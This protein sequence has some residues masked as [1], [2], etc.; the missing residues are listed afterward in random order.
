M[1][2]LVLNH[3]GQPSRFCDSKCHNSAHGPCDC[4]CEGLLHGHGTKYAQ[5]NAVKAEAHLSRLSSIATDQDFGPRIVNRK[6]TLNRPANR[7]TG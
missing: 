4:I 7:H 6:R 5:T 3:P 2:I 1:K